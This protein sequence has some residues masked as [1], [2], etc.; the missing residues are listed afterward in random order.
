MITAMIDFEC[1]NWL[2]KHIGSKQIQIMEVL[3]WIPSFCDRVKI[4][5]AGLIWLIE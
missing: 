1:S 3:S 5:L 4:L 2:D